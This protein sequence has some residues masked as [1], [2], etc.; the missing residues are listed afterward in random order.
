[1]IAAACVFLAFR[2]A[3]KDIKET[4][5]TANEQMKRLDPDNKDRYQAMQDSADEWWSALQ[6]D[7]EAIE[8]ALS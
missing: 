1:M 7:W 6:T 2:K 4:I 5:K 8:G 3:G